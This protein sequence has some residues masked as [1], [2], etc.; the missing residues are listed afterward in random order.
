M[1][2]TLDQTL[3]NFM[4]ITNKSKVAI[5]IPLFGYQ[6]TLKNKELDEETLKITLDRAYSQAHNV[7]YI[8]VGDQKSVSQEVRNIIVGKFQ[9]GNTIG[10]HVPGAATY[11]EY[12]KKGVESAL[13]ETEAEYITIINPWIVMQHGAI[14]TLVDRVNY[15]DDAC[16]VCGYDLR[17]EIDPE[18]FETY[19]PLAPKEEHSLSFDTLGMKRYTAET[20]K[21]DE[22][23]I[24]R[25][26]LERDMWQSLFRGGA[27]SICS[28]RIPIFS[29]DV[30]FSKLET[31]EEIELDRT[32]FISKWGFN[33]GNL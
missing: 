20:T 31:K 18:S 30:D 25:R 2:N 8:F 14:D 1:T 28:Q 24:T 12:I 29:F 33:P 19:K 11:T 5:I 4:K 15:G 9:A 10:V 23:Y 22:N 27:V 21:I 3:H 13:N 6:K 32:Y 17:K 26:F 7:Y 16:I